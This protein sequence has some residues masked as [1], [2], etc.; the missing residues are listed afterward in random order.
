[1]VNLLIS[2]ENEESLLNFGSQVILDILRVNFEC[3]YLIVLNL[4][5][6]VDTNLILVARMRLDLHDLT[7]D[8]FS[9]DKI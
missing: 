8:A 1:V 6:L 3:S 5:D 9:L 7:L 2:A 4:V